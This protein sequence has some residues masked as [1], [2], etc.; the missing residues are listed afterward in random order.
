MTLDRSSTWRA[1][2][3]LMFTL[4]AGAVSCAGKSDAPLGADVQVD[5]D[6]VVRGIPDKGRDP[7][8]VA[9]DLDG[10]GTCSGT[11]IAP[12][13]VLT[14]RHCVDRTLSGARCPPD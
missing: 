7:A 1:A 5:E 8:V 10:E 11:L 2:C 13:V 9:I 12:D 6:P 3:A 4:S 14:A